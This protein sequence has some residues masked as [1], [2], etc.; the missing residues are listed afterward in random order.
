MMMM[1]S[2]RAGVAGEAKAKA[3]ANRKRVN[4]TTIVRFMGIPPVFRVACNKVARLQSYKIATL[5]HAT[6]LFGYLLV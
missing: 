2:A 5:L 6:L 3:E 1:P 4:K